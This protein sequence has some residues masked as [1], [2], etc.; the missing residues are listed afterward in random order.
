MIG[1]QYGNLCKQ[2][3]F[4]Q[5]VLPYSQYLSVVFGPSF[6]GTRSRGVPFDMMGVVES[7]LEKKK[8]KFYPPLRPEKSKKIKMKMKTSLT[9]GEKKKNWAAKGSRGKINTFG[10]PVGKR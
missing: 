9:S 1:K 5:S 3:N 6:S 8:E 2:K 4:I 10:N 7:F